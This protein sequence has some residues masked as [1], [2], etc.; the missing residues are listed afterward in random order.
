MIPPLAVLT[1]SGMTHMVSICFK[2][3]NSFQSRRVVSASGTWVLCALALLRFGD[4]CM[5]PWFFTHLRD[6]IC[7]DGGALQWLK[8]QMVE[9]SIPVV[10]VYLFPGFLSVLLRFLA[11]HG[12]PFLGRHSPPPTPFSPF[13]PFSPHPHKSAPSWSS[14]PSPSPSPPQSACQSPSPSPSPSSSASSSS[15]SSPSLQRSLYYLSPESFRTSH[16]SSSLPYFPSYSVWVSSTS[17]VAP[18]SQKSVTSRWLQEQKS[19]C[20]R[21]SPFSSS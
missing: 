8:F 3:F 5:W 2:R 14:L 9:V 18:V 15:S 1:S 7:E 21:H 6:S 17:N 20:A 16:L 11:L 4:N 12:F 19:A 13:S 10:H